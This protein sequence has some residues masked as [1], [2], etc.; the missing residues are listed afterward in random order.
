MTPEQDQEQSKAAVLTEKLA[1]IDI[2]GFEVLPGE[3]NVEMLYVQG[4]L[5]CGVDYALS[6]PDEQLK[7]LIS[8][9]VES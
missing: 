2:V 5:I 8:E 4:K 6:M 7:A 3:E 9:T 1:R